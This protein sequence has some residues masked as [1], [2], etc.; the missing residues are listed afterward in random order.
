MAN[1]SWLTPGAPAH[2]WRLMREMRT[3]NPDESQ[4]VF[5]AFDL[6]VER[7]VD[8]RGLPLVERKKDLRRLCLKSKVPFL[9]EVEHFPD[10]QVL[11]EHCNAFGFEGVVSKKLNSRSVWRKSKCPNWRR[12]HAER[13][14]AFEKTNNQKP[15]L[16]ED[17]KVLIKKR[18][19]LARVL[20]SLQRPDLRP[21][22]ARELRGH[23]ALLE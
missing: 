6:L 15:E 20:E 12:Q 3:N 1:S 13:W 16:T 10:G 22:I 7:G 23:Q 21:G 2:F 19:E 11:Y 14:R 9:K 17:Q 18:A 4:L 5:L 8:L